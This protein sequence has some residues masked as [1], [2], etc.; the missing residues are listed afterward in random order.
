MPTSELQLTSFEYF[1]NEAERSV[2]RRELLAYLGSL[3][4][5]RIADPK[6]DLI[7]AGN[8][9]M[10]NM[11]NLGVVTL[12]EHPSQLEELRRDPLLARK[13]VEELCR[14]H[15]ASSFAT[16][17][18]AKV[19]ITLRDK[20]IKAGEGIIASNQSA[21]RDEDVFPDP[22]TFNMHRETDSEQNLAYGYGD[23]RCIAEV[24]AR[25]E[26]EAVFSCLFQRLPNLKLGVPHDQVRYSEAHKDVGI[27]ELP[28]TCA[29]T[30][31]E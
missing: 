11:I 18:V 8:A 16:R 20:H 19:D 9:T 4:D 25:A 28:V 17:R 10:V 12:L 31:H 23:H 7:M 26:L 30:E 27:D 6:K 22:D 14:F 5:K 21:N 29:S 3:V 15:V 1:D 2:Y 24:L 13:F